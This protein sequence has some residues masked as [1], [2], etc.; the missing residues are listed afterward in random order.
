MNFNNYPVTQKKLG[1]L[2][3][4][5]QTTFNVW[6]PTQKQIC[7]ALYKDARNLHRTLY[8]MEKEADGVFTVT[9]EGDLHGYFYTYIV[10]TEH[11]VTDPYSISASANS[12]RS[13]ILDLSKTN[14]QGWSTHARPRG[15]TGCDAVLYEMHVRDFTAHA[16]SHVQLKGKFLGLTENGTN[17]DGYVTGLDHLVRLGVTHVHLLPVYDYLTVDET[18]DQE[19]DYNWGYDPELFNAPEGS[20][21]TDPYDGATRVKELKSAIQALH[22]HGLKV[23]LDVVY[24][25]TYRTTD[26]NFNTLV[27]KYYHRT[28]KDGVFSNGSGCG[29][30]FASDHPMG[31]KFIVDSLCFW[32]EEYKVD[33]FRFDLMALIDLET[34]KVFQKALKKI[35]PEIMIYGEPWMGGLSTLPENKRVY[36]GA[37]CGKGFSLFNDDFRDAIKGDNDGTE[38]GYIHGNRDCVH[39]VKVGIT[40]SIA[41]D[42]TL[43]GFAEKPSETINYF[44]SHDNLI[45]MDK[46]TKTSPDANMETIIRQSKLA[47]GLLFTSQGIPFFHA[48]NEFLR[49]KKGHHNTYNASLDINAIRWH[50]KAKYYEFYK[51]VE[52]LIKMRKTLSCLRMDN[53]KHIQ[54]RLKFYDGDALEDGVI[55]YTIKQTPDEDF[56]CLLVVHN[57]FDKQIM[58]SIHDLMMHMCCDHQDLPQNLKDCIKVE[59]IFDENGLFSEPVEIN[60]ATHHLVK[61]DPISTNVFKFY[62]LM[63]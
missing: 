21:A 2:Y 35:D 37:Q 32:A 51:Y 42:D 40:G 60:P 25:H 43:V 58:L 6:A 22:A 10:D 4:K 20:Y 39:D 19:D 9:V 26:S 13:A 31:R 61:V 33:G 24:N 1:A 7:L 5:D 28:T 41:Y 16:T 3:A 63:T 50:N 52:D 38:K 30:E 54:E 14:P 62:N 55:V 46:L 57:P 18:E 47:F 44:N 15:N 27:P 45:L 36:K 53:P 11:E 49:D 12:L 59:H 8:E 23:I 48:G 29:N 17:C 56:D 34:V